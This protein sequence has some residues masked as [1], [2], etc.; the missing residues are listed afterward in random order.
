MKKVVDHFAEKKI[1]LFE[2]ITQK[3]KPLQE[4]VLVLEIAYNATIAL[5]SPCITLSDVFGIWTKMRIHLEACAAKN[6]FKTMLSQNL[7]ESLQARYHTVFDNPQMKCSLL[8]DPRFRNVILKDRESFDL[9]KST[10][11]NLYHRLNGLHE[12]SPIIQTA[13]ASSDLHLSFDEQSEL[14]KL[15]STNTS[16]NNTDRHLDIEEAIIL[17]QPNIL[18]S[19]KSVLDFWETQKHSI[20][21]DLAMAV[22]SIPP[23]QV[24]IER[25]FSSLGHIFT[26]RRYQ[27]SQARL[28][29]ILLIHFNKDLFFI[30]KEEQLSNV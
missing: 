24:Q 22:Y 23:T 8:L 25:D 11:V 9:A 4:L 26:E 20:L 6:S 19:E 29:Q 7:I 2:M 10:L 3:W 16:Q 15:M 30:V 17:F 21:Y 12:P 1:Q 27:L 14:N 5:Q 28:E 13:N 18:P